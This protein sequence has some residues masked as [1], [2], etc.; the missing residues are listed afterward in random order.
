MQKLTTIQ[1]PKQL[2]LQNII[3]FGAFILIGANDGAFGVILPALLVF[4]HIDKAT[5]SL[6]FF[7]SA[8]G[9]LIA[10]FNSG[11][12]VAKLGERRFLMLGAAIFG[13]ATLLLSFRPIFPLTLS[14][15][16]PL[17]FGIAVLDAGLNSVIAGRVNSGPL[18]NY[19]HAFYG[20]GAW[21]GPIFATAF[22][23]WNIGWNNIY[24]TWAIIGLVLVGAFH[25]TFQQKTKPDSN[26]V[27]APK[28]NVMKEALKRHAVWIAAFFLFFYVGV[29]V[30][31]GNWGYSFLLENR[32]EAVWL[33]GWTISGY[34]L[35]LT[36]GRVILGHFTGR[37]G[38][39]AMIQLCI[40]GVF[41]GLLLTWFVPLP[42][43][44][45]ASILL[46]GFFLG[47][48][49]PTTVALIP[50]IVPSRLIASAIG[51]LT[52]LASMG[53]SFFPWLAGNTAQRIGI[54]S[55]IPYVLIL[56]IAML[57]LWL[58]LQ[59]QRRST[60]SEGSEQPEQ[61]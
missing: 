22:L 40:I 13:L 53:A 17:G 6:L 57:V 14:L 24:L 15:V 61:G 41:C 38:S 49:F 23:A 34:W 28:S 19:L 37:I 7:S 12:L 9:Y 51:F 27:D 25:F 18:L 8:L 10:A 42:P 33:A 31:F 3:A 44:N 48:I 60:V 5:I 11:L 1:T 30:T 26:A 16:L 32:Q 39:R 46:T 20:V 2:H 35:G 36:L 55:L 45:F 52:S 47:P 21:L 4:Y 58:L 54:W 43:L 50:E 56:T 59:L 29:E